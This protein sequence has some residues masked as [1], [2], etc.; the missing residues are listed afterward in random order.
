MTMNC[1]QL[2]CLF[3][4][5]TFYND[6]SDKLM[7]LRFQIFR[8]T[9]TI[10]TELIVFKQT[11]RKDFLILMKSKEFLFLFCII[12]SNLYIFEDAKRLYY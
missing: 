4:T 11:I 10:I 7:G 5:F 9:P 2:R 12:Y 3:W 1:Y 6:T 8:T